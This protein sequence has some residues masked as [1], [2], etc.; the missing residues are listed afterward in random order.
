MNLKVKKLTFNLNHSIGIAC[1]TNCMDTTLTL[2][3]RDWDTV[4]LL[5][6]LHPCNCFQWLRLKV[7]TFIFNLN[8]WIKK[9]KNLNLTFSFF[10]LLPF[11]PYTFWVLKLTI[12]WCNWPNN[13]TG[14][15]SSNLIPF[16]VSSSFRHF[17]CFFKWKPACL[18][19]AFGIVNENSL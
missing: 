3:N 12:A 18:Y 17:L 10:D 11:Y 1:N 19:Q 14:S 2:T 9:K 5:G 4:Q 13:C 15:Q 6:Q 16:T 8:I 7:E